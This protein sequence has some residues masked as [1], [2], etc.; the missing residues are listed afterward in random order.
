MA[1]ER[2]ISTGRVFH[3]KVKRL[4]QYTLFGVSLLANCGQPLRTGNTSLDQVEDVVQEPGE[5]QPSSSRQIAYVRSDGDIEQLIVADEQGLTIRTY[6]LP[7]AIPRHRGPC[8]S[9]DGAKILVYYDG[10][11][12]LFQLDIATGSVDLLVRTAEWTYTNLIGSAQG[13]FAFLGNNESSSESEH[14]EIF[15]LRGTDLERVTHTLGDD[16][17]PTWSP[18]GTLAYVSATN[19][20]LS[21]YFGIYLYSEGRHQELNTGVSYVGPLAWSP[22]G[23]GLAFLGGELTDVSLYYLALSGQVTEHWTNQSARK[24]QWA[25]N[26][27]FIM[28][29]D[30]F[31]SHHLYRWDVAERQL[32]PLTTNASDSSPAISSDSKDVLFVRSRAGEQNLF[33]MR[34]DGT[35]VQQLTFFEDPLKAY[36]AEWQGYCR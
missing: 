24:M 31:F 11:R 21:P 13:D 33:R 18:N 7:W 29:D 22:D 2:I 32:V 17:S 8:W 19:D 6:E 27:T 20:I 35:E 34:W 14:S 3:N 12:G 28:M 4:A 30:G 23:Q 1:L 26:G 10:N 5:E 15:T 9:A 16:Y 25:P 36:P